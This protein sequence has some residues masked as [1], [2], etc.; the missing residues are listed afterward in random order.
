MHIGDGDFDV[1]DADY[2]MEATWSEVCTA[3][4]VRTPAEWGMVFV[5]IV[6]VLFFL[7]FFLVGLDVTREKGS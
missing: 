4:C 6:F 1:N 7:Y 2:E 3:C 5:G